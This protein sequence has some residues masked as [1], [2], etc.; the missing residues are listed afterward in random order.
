MKK[1]PKW[2]S[3]SGILAALA[4]FFRY[5]ARGYAYIAYTLVF[6]A[7]LIVLHH[8]AGA[9]LWRIILILVGIGLMYF[10]VVENLII[11]NCRTDTDADSKYVIVLG[12]AVYGDVPSK[13]LA[14][15]MIGAMDYLETHPDSKL[16]VSG[17]QGDGE[18]ITDA[19]CLFRYL[20]AHG[21]EPQRIIM[22][23]R[24]TSTMENLQNSFAIIRSLGDDPNGNVAIV[25]SSY[26]LYRAKMMAKNLGV[27]A[28][29]IAGKMGYP[30]VMINYYIRE[31]FGVTHLWV[32]GR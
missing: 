6:V 9:A 31:A 22:E 24:S 20:T 30:L 19:E 15:R 28:A 26:H 2:A 10:C 5:A 23:D 1:I 11:S 25:S 29:G 3:L 16:I 18:D 27:E 17:G 21:V 13:T 32:F 8:F 14:N 7:A 12:A 4:F